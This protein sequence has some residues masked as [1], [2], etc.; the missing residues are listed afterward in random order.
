MEGRIREEEGKRKGSE[1]KGT[2]GRGWDRPPN[3]LSRAFALNIRVWTS[4][5]T[6]PPPPPPAQNMKNILG[7]LVG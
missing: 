3:M 2:G 1:G 4:R 7:R 5:P 6:S